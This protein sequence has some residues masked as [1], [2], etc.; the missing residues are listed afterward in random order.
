MN[1]EDKENNKKEKKKENYG[2][3]DF[4]ENINNVES[5]LHVEEIQR[6]KRSSFY[7]RQSFLLQWKVDSINLECL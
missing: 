4:D 3:K 2:T 6:K 7:D 5:V 1:E